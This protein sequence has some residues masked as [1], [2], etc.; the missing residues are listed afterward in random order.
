MCGGRSERCGIRRTSH[1]RR[2]DPPGPVR[3]YSRATCRG[4]GTARRPIAGA[5][6]RNRWRLALMGKRSRLARPCP[7]PRKARRGPAQPPHSWGQSGERNKRRRRTKAALSN[8]DETVA[9]VTP[10]RGASQRSRWPGRLSKPGRVRE[11]GS[12]APAGPHGEV[13][14]DFGGEDYIQFT[15]TRR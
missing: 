10:N 5:G 7:S 12:Y 6:G 2:S 9:A 1:D 14:G 8:P 15:A 3:S 13:V 4:F 11:E